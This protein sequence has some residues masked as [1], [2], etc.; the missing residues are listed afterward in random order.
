MIT[1]RFFES[2]DI[3]LLELSLARDEQHIGT[4]PEF[5]IQP[6]TIA[7]VYE[8]E[9]G[10]ILFLRGAKA[11]RLDAQFVD[12]NDYKRNMRAMLVG[13]DSLAK[14][15]AEHG[16]TEIVFTTNNQA[17]QKFC[18]KRCGFIQCEGEIRRYI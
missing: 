7:K 3:N 2:G 1:D 5:F 4:K 13:F 9:Q 18:V 10:P 12:N 16:F 6:G 14:K 8:D 11:L 17:F 15:A